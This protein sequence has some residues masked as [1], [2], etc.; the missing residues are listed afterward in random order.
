MKKRFL[1]PF[2]LLAGCHI[3]TLDESPF[4]TYEVRQN[5]ENARTKCI[6]EANA[7]TDPQQ[8]AKDVEKCKARSCD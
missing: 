3:S 8:R 5:C 1:A 7:V 2:L 4:Y 6:A